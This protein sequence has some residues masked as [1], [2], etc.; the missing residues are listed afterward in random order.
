[1]FKSLKKLLAPKAKTETDPIQAQPDL[2]VVLVNAYCTKGAIPEC[3]FPHQL[4]HRRD[5]SDPELVQHLNGFAGYVESRGNTGMSRAKYHVIRHIQRTRQHLSFSIE[6]SQ[7][8]AA[9]DWAVRANALLFLPDGHVRDPKWRILVSAID[10]DS[11]QDAEIPYPV[12]AWERKARTESFLATKNLSVP[13]HLPPLVSETELRLRDPQAVAGRALALFVVAIRAE[14]LAT[15]D[16][17]PVSHLRDHFPVAFTWL[18]QSEQSFLNSEKPTATEVAQFAWRYECLFLL[19]WAL[20]LVENLPFP[21]A[22]CDVSLTAR[23]I[24]TLD[25]DEFLK[26]ATMR[27]ASEILDALDLHYRLHWLVRQA[28][29]TNNQVPAS[30]EGGVILERHYGL[31]WLVRFEDSEWDRVDT[32]T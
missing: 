4:N 20:G 6:S 32:P 8:A 25:Q 16:P 19:I 18:T 13:L 30:C 21:G 5:L 10:G 9:S 12:E 29:H 23:L 15:N 11:D 22:I 17:V 24:T 27:S 28:R 2:G 1:M 31:N 3:Q 7:M 14:S 26:T